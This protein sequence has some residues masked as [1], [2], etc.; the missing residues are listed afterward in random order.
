MSEGTEERQLIL[1]TV[2]EFVDREVIPVASAM[3]HRGEYPHALA[4]QMQKIGLFGLNVPE[5]FGG[6]EVDYVTFAHIFVELARGWLGLAGIAVTIA[7][8]AAFSSSRS[9]NAR[10]AMRL[11]RS[12]R[13]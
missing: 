3:E 1:R 12:V 5:E 9:S 4:D 6:T 7:T 11:I 2:R 8:G 13:K 10:P